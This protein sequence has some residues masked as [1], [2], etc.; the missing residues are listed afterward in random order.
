MLVSVRL[1][2]ESV[3]SIPILNRVLPYHRSF[4][5]LAL[6]DT[7]RGHAFYFIPTSSM[8][9]Y[10]MMAVVPLARQTS[11]VLFYLQVRSTWCMLGNSHLNA[12]EHACVVYF[13]VQLGEGI[14]QMTPTRQTQPFTLLLFQ[15]RILHLFKMFS[16]FNF[17]EKKY[18]T[19]C[20][21]LARQ[22]LFLTSHV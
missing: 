12:N 9:H 19:T 18:Y 8:S 17:L 14:L 6:S 11:P 13:I 20:C 7:G 16:I 10:F 15:H 4:Q 21:V 2:S 3:V 22:P 1:L 5:H